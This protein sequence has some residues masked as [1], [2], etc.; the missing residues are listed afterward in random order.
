V[1]GVAI[2]RPGQTPRPPRP[3][4][5]PRS[6]AFSV[7]YRRDTPTYTFVRLRSATPVPVAALF[8]GSLRL[9][10]GVAGALLQLPA[11]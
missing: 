2:H 4:H 9:S 3:A 7:T 8:V 10:P 6:P 5:A 11:R 1:I